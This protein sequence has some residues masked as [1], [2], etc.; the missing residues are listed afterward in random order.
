MNRLAT[1]SVLV[2]V[3]VFAV[4]GALIV[5][6]GQRRSPPVTG[7]PVASG[8]TTSTME[9]ASAAPE[10]ASSTRGPGYHPSATRA[11]TAQSPQSKLWFAAGRWWGI[12][13]NVNDRFSIHWLDWRTQVWHDTGTL[14]DERSGARADA[15][16][17]DGKLYIAT[18]GSKPTAAA[19]AIRVLRFSFDAADAR[20]ILDDGFP[21][22]LT[23]GGA[24]YVTIARDGSGRLWIAYLGADGLALMSTD[25]DDHRW[26]PAFRPVAP[27]DALPAETA[28]IVAQP[29]R[30]VLVWTATADDAVYSAMHDAGEPPRQGWR[31]TRT[32]VDGLVNGPDQLDVKA[33]DRTG[34]PVFAAIRTSLGE[35]DN[36]N[37]RDPQVLL[38]ELRADGS[39]AQ[40]VVSLVTDHGTWPLISIDEEGSSVTVFS[41]APGAGGR[42]YAK[43]AAIGALD[44][45]AGIGLSFVASD[46]DGQI[47]RPTTTKQPVSAATGLVVLA[48]DDRTGRYVHGARGLGGVAPGSGEHTDAS[49]TPAS[50]ETGAVVFSDVFDAYPDHAPMPKGWQ[51]SDPGTGTLEIVAAPSADDHSARLAAASPALAAT[52]CRALP[53]LGGGDLHAQAQ[54]MVFGGPATDDAKLI[55]LRGRGLEL[56]SVRLNEDGTLGYFS[57]SERQRVDSAF[58]RERWFGVEVTMHLD[59]RSYDWTL[60]D[61]SSDTQVATA[62]NVPWRAT[63]RVPDRLCFG[64]ATGPGSGILFDDVRVTR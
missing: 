33:G 4:I 54:V 47:N 55:S 51:L 39:W 59:T 28:A 23:D 15:L 14:V 20:Y 49:S 32:A 40:T 37:G 17:A 24:E 29:D 45:G 1:A 13:A 30:V 46:Q 7:S 27:A 9:S 19:D 35:R 53:A 8:P 10:V 62:T 21:V 44:F 6:N 48:A 36:A 22:L 18:A 50:S 5:A 25:G 38:L 60:S 2:L 64:T 42:V 52:V 26:S 16:W 63:D 3:L 11:P 58:D 56:A 61:I 43:T 12:L 57:G 34:G 31:V 41:V